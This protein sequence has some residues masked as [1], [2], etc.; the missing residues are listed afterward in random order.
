MKK[1]ACALLQGLEDG[2]EE[3]DSVSVSKL[4]LQ[5]TIQSG[6]SLSEGVVRPQRR[7]PQF[8]R[9]MKGHEPR[10]GIERVAG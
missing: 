5:L 7:I 10:E 8:E 9:N 2:I 6:N 3:K 1:K 4:I